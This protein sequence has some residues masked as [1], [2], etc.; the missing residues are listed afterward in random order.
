MTRKKGISSF[1]VFLIA[2]SVLLCLLIGIGLGWVWNLL[3]DYEAGLPE[4]TADTVLLRFEP[5]RIEETLKKAEV[6]VSE[7]ENVNMIAGNYQELLSDK[8]ITYRRKGG[9]YTASYPVYNVF[10]DEE[11]FAEFSLKQTG[12]NAHGFPSWEL[13]KV[14]FAKDVLE[15]RKL[16]LKVPRDAAVYVNGVLADPAKYI[17]SKEEIELVKNIGEYVKVTA[18]Y[19]SYTIEELTSKPEVELKDCSAAKPQDTDEG[20][21]YDYAP[22]EGLIS[23]NEELLRRISENYAGYLINRVTFRTLS[24]DLVGEANEKLSDIPAIWAYLYAEEYTYDITDW[25]ASNGKQY[26]EDCF[27]CDLSF[28]LNVHYR[29][30]KTISYETKLSCVFVRQNSIWMMADFII[31]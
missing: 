6:S 22:A 19:D 1:A 20:I 24:K 7:F 2:Y 9:E 15:S 18:G 13:D 31:G 25:S 16:E 28:N 8:T 12:T 14:S 17:S 23:Q 30:T 5:E 26:S 21:F 29:V 27:S 11:I 3:I 4:T 10:A